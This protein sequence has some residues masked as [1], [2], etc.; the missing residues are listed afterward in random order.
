[1]TYPRVLELQIF[2]NSFLSE[3]NPSESLNNN[4]LI[5]DSYFYIGEFLF[6][7]P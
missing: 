2:L 4:E 3:K 1:M 5:M 6:A 7:C